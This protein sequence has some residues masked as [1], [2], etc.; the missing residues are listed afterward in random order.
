M[1]LIQIINNKV[2]LELSKDELILLANALNE[3]CNGLELWEFDTRIGMS[4]DDAKL[5]LKSLS[6]VMN[7]VEQSK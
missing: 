5:A 4:M 1:Q 7:Q 2:T 3:I 6:A